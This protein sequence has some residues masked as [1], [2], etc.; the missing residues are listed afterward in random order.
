MRVAE[1]GAEIGRN[2]GQ[3]INQSIK[4]ENIFPGLFDEP[5]SENVFNGKDDGDDCEV[6]AA[7]QTD[8]NSKVTSTTATG[9]SETFSWTK[10]A[11]EGFLN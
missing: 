8:A 7:T 10:A 3:E 5:D 9:T 4:A 1:E 6:T 2:D 11:K